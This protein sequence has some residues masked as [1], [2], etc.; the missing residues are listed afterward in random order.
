MGVKQ[1][2]RQPNGTAT[3]RMAAAI[4]VAAAVGSASGRP[5]LASAQSRSGVGIDERL[6]SSVPFD[7]Q[8]IDEQGMAVRLGQLARAPVILSLVYYRCKNSCDFLLTGEAAALAA[9]DA[10]PG[11]DYLALT[12]SFDDREGPEDARAAKRVALES[13]QKPFP[14][15]GW[16]FLTGSEGDLGRL[17]DAVGFRYARTDDGFD[18]PLG[19]IILSPSGK[20]VRYMNGA[21]FLPADLTLSLMEASTGTV[22]PTIAKVLRFCF[23]YD[24]RSRA[25]VFNTLKISAI[26]VI[27]L[28]AALALYLLF[29]GKKRRATARGAR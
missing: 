15:D 23:S 9:M 17:T 1:R 26:L 21:D 2:G 22:R 5:E 19:L 14:V 10:K 18:H 11:L 8:L 7:L 27:A 24:P 29:G 28:A 13:M 6:G 16:R 25:L 3:V 12:V 20:I 4:L